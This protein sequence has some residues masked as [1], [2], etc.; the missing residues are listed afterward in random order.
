MSGTASRRAAASIPVQS[1]RPCRAQS[2]PVLGPSFLRCLGQGTTASDLLR[3]ARQGQPKRGT[4]CRTWLHR[5]R[6][7]RISCALIL[8]AKTGAAPPSPRSPEASHGSAGGSPTRAISA[9]A[10]RMAAC[11]ASARERLPP[12]SR[13]P[14]AP[15]Q[16]QTCRMAAFFPLG[17]SVSSVSGERLRDTPA[18]PSSIP[19]SCSGIRLRSSP[20]PLPSRGR[21]ETPGS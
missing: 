19:T 4:P 11:R 13:Q 6:R 12:L 10:I 5:R 9:G 8:S 2:I 1:R 7:S 20:R 14:Q 18:L 3:L 21:A 17:P 15:S 16:D